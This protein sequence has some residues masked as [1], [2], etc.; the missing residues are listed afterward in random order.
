M[1]GERN[2]GKEEKDAGSNTSSGIGAVIQKAL[3]RAMWVY[4]RNQGCWE[5]FTSGGTGVSGGQVRTNGLERAM[6]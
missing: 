2:T 3:V 1:Y 5:D 4:C 6:G